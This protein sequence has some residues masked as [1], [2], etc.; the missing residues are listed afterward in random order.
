MKTGVKVKNDIFNV[1]IYDDNFLNVFKQYSLDLGKSLKDLNFKFRNTMDKIN[2][3]SKI[4]KHRNS[5][6]CPI[7]NNFNPTIYNKINTH[8]WFSIKETVEEPNN[9]IDTKQHYLE[10]NEDVKYKCK[11]I[12]L[13]LTNKQKHIVNIWLNSF[14]EMYNVALKYIKEN[15]NDKKVFN[16]MYLRN[17][18]KNEKEILVKKSFNI[19]V[20]D[21]DYAIKLACQNYKSADTNF[22][23]GNIKTF[24]I[25]YWRRN[26]TVKI[27][28]ME[29]NNFSG[30]SIRKNILGEVKG[31]Y[32]GK[33]FNFSDI[34]CDSRLQKKGGNYYLFVPILLNE[35]NNLHQEGTITI[36]PGIRRFGTAIT[37]N[38]VV[39]IGENCSEKIKNYFLRKDKILSNPNINKNTKSKNEKMINKKIYNLVEDLHWKTLNYLTKNYKTI[40]IG[41]ISSKSIVSKSGN[42]NKMTKRIALSLRFNDFKKRLKFKSELRKLNCGII[43]EWM[44]SKMCSLCGNIKE[45]LGGNEIYE[46]LNC[47]K[48]IER[49]IN[50]SRNIYIVSIKE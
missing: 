22:K 12:E 30:N 38:K 27:M 50:G 8:S 16:F 42:L 9:P 14:A 6:W 1:N 45:N 3:A 10:T 15:Y 17:L 13:D 11:R 26:K 49:D 31:Y 39:K 48:K 28:D 23:K 18:L 7:Y 47:N 4:F 24:R 21:I 5:I 32:N 29:K 44:T 41:N 40:L 36:D 33:R 43:N 20:H 25:R 34:D 37:H 46:C 2:M 19:K 35:Q